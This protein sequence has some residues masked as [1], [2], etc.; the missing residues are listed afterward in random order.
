MV[1]KEQGLTFESIPDKDQRVLLRE[2][3]NIS[4]G[5]DSI[6]MTDDVDSSYKRIA[7]AMARIIDVQITGIDLI[8]PDIHKPSTANQPGYTLIEMNYNPAMNMHAYVYKGKGRRVTQDVL[9][10]LFPEIPKRSN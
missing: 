8:I 10:L 1:L 2:N 5:G 7:E 9:N 6:D 3:T 4:T